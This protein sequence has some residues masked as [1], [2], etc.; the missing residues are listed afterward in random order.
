MVQYLTATQHT[1]GIRHHSAH[2][3]F[4]PSEKQFT[5]AQSGSL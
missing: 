5:S 3:T 4:F 2:M 1:V